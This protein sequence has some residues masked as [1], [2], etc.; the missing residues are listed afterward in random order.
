MHAIRTMGLYTVFL[1]IVFLR[2]LLFFELL[3]PW[4]SNT[5]SALSFFLCNENLNSFLT[6]V[7]KLFKGGNYS[8]E[9]TFRGNT[10]FQ[11]HLLKVK[12]FFVRGLFL[13]ILVLCTN[14]IQKRF[15]NICKLWW[16]AYVWT[17][18]QSN[19][20]STLDFCPKAPDRKETNVLLHTRS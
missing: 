14:C 15:I 9:E 12:N 18:W 5:V 1:W 8:R 7:R 19:M 13:E 17:F 2:K 4:K 20:H 6:R 3:K 16:Q 11:T 10:V